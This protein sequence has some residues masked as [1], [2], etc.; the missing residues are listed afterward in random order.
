[1][2]FTNI[3][4]DLSLIW[5]LAA[6]ILSWHCFTRGSSLAMASLAPCERDC[7]SRK[8][9]VVRAEIWA[10]CTASSASLTHRSVSFALSLFS[11]LR[12]SSPATDSIA[13]ATLSSVSISFFSASSSS[14]LTARRC[15]TEVNNFLCLPTSVWAVLNLVWNLIS[16]VLT[17]TEA[18]LPLASI[19]RAVTNLRA[20]T[21]TSFASFSQTIVFSLATRICSAVSSMSLVSSAKTL[22]VSF[23]LST[24]AS[25]LATRDSASLTSARRF[26]L[27]TALLSSTSRF[28]AS[29]SCF[30]KS[31]SF[32][33]ASAAGPLENLFTSRTFIWMNILAMEDAVCATA[34]AVSESLTVDRISSRGSSMPSWKRA[35][36]S[37]T[38][39]SASVT[40]P[41]LAAASSR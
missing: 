21:R 17:S 33:V 35:S 19:C 41:S 16:S 7:A 23:T 28:V 32:W 25:A 22:A 9:A 31:V 24:S 3:F 15:S 20:S 14:F 10:S 5:V 12:A 38:L 26:L 27:F 37:S 8:R 18:S 34:A 11:M 1:M 30:W 4:S 29:S 13:L 2:F 39:P 36:Q 6:W 40:A